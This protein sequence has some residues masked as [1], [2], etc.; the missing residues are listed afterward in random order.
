MCEVFLNDLLGQFSVALDSVEAGLVGATPYHGKRVAVLSM[1]IGSALGWQSPRLTG[2]GG[3]A[4]LHDNALTEYILS[5][6]PNNQQKLNLKTHCIL[7]QQNCQCLPFAQNIDGFVLYH[8]ECAD[9]T[10]PFGLM[11]GEYPEEAG[12][13]ALADQTDVRFRLQTL[14]RGGLEPLKR[15]LDGNPHF[16]KT[17]SQA[18]IAALDGPL[19]DSLRDSEIH[20]TL[21]KAMPDQKRTLSDG[22]IISLAEIVSKIID[23]KSHFTKEHTSQIANK[24]WMIS[25]SYGNSRSQQARLFLAA[26]LH[27]LGKLMTPLSILEKPGAL[28]SEEFSVIK[29]HVLHTWELLSPIR[30]LEQITQWAANHHEKLDGSGYPFGKSA[31]ELDFNSRLMACI[32]IYQAVREARP[33]H[34][35][36]SHKDTMQI[37]NSMAE[38]GKVDLSIVRDLDRVFKDLTDGYAPPPEL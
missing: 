11:E 35:A 10:G 13:I 25:A 33:Y 3:C 6:N 22:E 14:D 23:Y 20:W 27:D 36:R 2:L 24:A 9:G 8:H 1:A 38:N 30:G 12:I 4:L 7:G 21:A 17:H 32:D 26:A 18:A 5:E 31:A 37:L 19:L 34:T 16:S 28:T 29:Q 15:F